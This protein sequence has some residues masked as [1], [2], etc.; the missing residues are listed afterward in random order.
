MMTP[1]FIFYIMDQSVDDPISEIKP[2]KLF[3]KILK[4]MFFK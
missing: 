2:E 3:D 1:N 4:K